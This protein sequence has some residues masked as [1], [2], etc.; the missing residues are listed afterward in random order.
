MAIQF[1]LPE[2]PL[3]IKNSIVIFGGSFNP[4]HNGH[5]IIAQLV[6][7]LFKYSD[8]HIIPNSTPPHKKVEV[9]FS[10]RFLMTKKTFEKINNI[11]VSDIE[12]KLGGISYAINTIKYYENQYNKIFYLV[13]EDSLLSIDKW[14][15]Y[16]EILKRVTLIVYPRYRT[17]IKDKYEQIENTI[18][19]LP[20]SIYLLDL[21]LIEI[22][23]SLIRQRVKEGKSIYGFVPDSII[24]IVKEV[25]S[26]R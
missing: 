8:M 16:E 1:G 2:K 25:Y 6:R 24:D 15:K 20:H 26:D 19:Y 11:V 10:K 13:G 4:P 5:I 23:S 18:K 14:Y 21:P 3:N 12:N 22:S 9:S 17:K 7:E